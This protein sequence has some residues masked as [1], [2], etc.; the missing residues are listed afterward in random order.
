MRLSRKKCTHQAP[1]KSSCFAYCQSTL[2]VKVTLFGNVKTRSGISV[3]AKTWGASPWGMHADSTKRSS[4]TNLL[5]NCATQ[6]RR[7]RNLVL[8]ALPLATTLN[9]HKLFCLRPVLCLAGA[10]HLLTA[11]VRCCGQKTFWAFDKKLW[12]S[13]WHN[14]HGKWNVECRLQ[15][16]LNFSFATHAPKLAHNLMLCCRAPCWWVTEGHW[17]ARTVLNLSPW[18]SSRN[19]QHWYF[20]ALRNFEMNLG[21]VHNKRAVAGA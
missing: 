9:L 8:S 16:I 17:H 20:C 12:P 5:W 3:S 19:K 13:H 18:L 7:E 1:H 2:S 21:R 10:V 6:C 15:D 11:V 14:W 4:M